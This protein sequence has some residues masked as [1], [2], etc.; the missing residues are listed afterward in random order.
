MAAVP[1]PIAAG[2]AGEAPNAPPAP[3]PLAAAPVEVGTTP[4]VEAAIDVAAEA[5][6]TLRD[7]AAAEEDAAGVVGCIM[8]DTEVPWEPLEYG[9][10]GGD[11]G[12]ALDGGFW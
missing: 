9:A 10:M 11:D 8:G 6:F 3:A 12:P 5:V 4:P 7:R 2:G 1:A